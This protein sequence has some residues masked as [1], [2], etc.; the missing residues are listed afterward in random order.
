MKKLGITLLAL[1]TLVACGGGE[2]SS[3]SMVTDE[4][5]GVITA[6]NADTD[7]SA[8]VTF[9]VYDGE[10]IYLVGDL[11]AGTITVTFYEGD[12]TE[13]ESVAYVEISGNE[14]YSVTL[15]EGEY[16]MVAGVKEKAT[17]TVTS[18]IEK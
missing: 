15:P 6:E 12:T 17:G 16:T 7:N 14:D 10:F 5:K 13:G 4:Q 1:V 8:D 18:T 3:F 2:V 9:T 11:Q